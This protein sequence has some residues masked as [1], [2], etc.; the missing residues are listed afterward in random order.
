MP[1]R[2]EPDVGK[3]LDALRESAE[4]FQEAAD[5]ARRNSKA[6]GDETKEKERSASFFRGSSGAFGLAGLAAG[7]GFVGMGMQAGGRAV[8]YGG[9]AGADDLERSVQRLVGALPG[10]GYA[11]GFA[12]KTQ[13]MDRVE[14]R[15]LGATGDVARY[16][17]DAAS[18]REALAPIILKQEKA[19]QA[20]KEAVRNTVNRMGA[21]EEDPDWLK[22]VADRLVP[23]LDRIVDLLEFLGMD[24][25]KAF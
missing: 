2:G 7:G 20:E 19:F 13:T 4:A 16:G 11:S 8:A 14:A 9:Q 18:V 6:T 15:L 3:L 25:P 1:P 5:A 23:Y 24:R 10:I 22:A 17:G 21:R 12:Q